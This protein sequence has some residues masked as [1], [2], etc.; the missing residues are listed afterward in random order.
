MK[1]I[2][3]ARA[4][5]AAASSGTILMVVR[6]MIP[7]RAFP[8]AITTREVT[9]NQD[10]KALTPHSRRSSPRRGPRPSG[11]WKPLSPNSLRAPTPLA[12]DAERKQEVAMGREHFVGRRA[13]H[14]DSGHTGVTLDVHL[15][16][17]PQ[18]AKFQHDDG[19][20]GDANWLNLETLKVLPPEAPET[21]E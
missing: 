3:T 4:E 7:V 18:T 5:E 19:E 12:S 2:N 20:P 13:Y 21:D 14:E 11:S 8:V 15:D 6:G 1:G 17:R 10:M 9:I 16:V